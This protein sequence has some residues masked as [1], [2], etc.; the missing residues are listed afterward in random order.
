M[1]YKLSYVIPA[2]DNKLVYND[3]ELVKNCCFRPDPN[4]VGINASS[5]LLNNKARPC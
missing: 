3:D 5:K 4:K 2:G 1:N